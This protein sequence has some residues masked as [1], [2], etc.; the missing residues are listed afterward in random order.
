MV[1]EV[2]SRFAVFLMVTQLNTVFSPAI[3]YVLGYR[4]P[5][6]TQKQQ[7]QHQQ[8]L[9][10]QQQQKKL[11]M[12]N[13]QKSKT[14]T[15]NQR[16][17][18]ANNNKPLAKLPK[19]AQIVINQI[20]SLKNVAKPQL[21]NQHGFN[22]A[23]SILQPKINK[24][25]KKPAKIRLQQARHLSPVRIF[26]NLN[27]A[28]KMT[29]KGTT[30]KNTLKPNIGHII[31]N[32]LF[33]V[34]NS[35]GSSRSSIANTTIKTRQLKKKVTASQIASKR[36]FGG[37]QT[38]STIQDLVNEPL[39]RKGTD[40][41][42]QPSGIIPRSALNQ[43]E[44]QESYSK[45]KNNQDT[46]EAEIADNGDGNTEERDD[47][48]DRDT[49][50]FY[51]PHYRRRDDD[52]DESRRRHWEDEAPRKR[53]EDDEEEEEH[54]HM[55]ENT[56]EHSSFE[57]RLTERLLDAILSEHGH[58]EHHEHTEH[59]EHPNLG[60]YHYSYSFVF[61]RMIIAWCTART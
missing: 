36:S 7:K 1:T 31:P 4:Q 29:G 53:W 34:Q 41:V 42:I 24:N 3:K 40:Q 2:L 8:Q 30:R 51:E 58:N 5:S 21:N 52:Y 46:Y 44:A 22:V 33:T 37:A 15:S 11:Q 13:Q 57:H 47:D 55:H 25:F 14:K 12:Q 17:I 20:G 10:Q 19:S 61:E 35:R 38:R 54:H 23:S 60:E 59:N 43:I 50:S 18:Q 9:Q 26:S 28:I 16:N 32:R 6:Q 56:T 39:F 45:D 48:D 27:N 49:K